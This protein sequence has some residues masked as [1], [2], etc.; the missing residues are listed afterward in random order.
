[1]A[2]RAA[3]VRGCCWCAPVVCGPCSYHLCVHAPALSRTHSCMAARLYTSMAQRKAAAV[4][5]GINYPYHVGHMGYTL[6]L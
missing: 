5:K 4:R 3:G 1:M 6:H 2:A